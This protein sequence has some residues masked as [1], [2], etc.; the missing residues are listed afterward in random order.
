VG[1][2]TPRIVGHDV[3]SSE[4]TLYRIRQAPNLFIVADVEQTAVRLRAH[5]SHFPKR[6]LESALI[7]MPHKKNACAFARK[8]PCHAPPDSSARAGN[9]CDLAG[10][11][12][13][14]CILLFSHS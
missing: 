1:L 12:H 4:S 10:E 7:L 13:P 5:L 2:I 3:E 14:D 6:L 9:E 11:L 8:R